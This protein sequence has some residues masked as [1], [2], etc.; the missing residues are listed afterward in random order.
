MKI[1][2]LCEN[3]SSGIGCLAE[4]GFSSFIQVHGKNLLFDTGYSDVY[5]HNAKGAGI[6]LESTDFILC[7]HFHSDH[8]GGLRYHTFRSKKKIIFH[9]EVLLKLPPE[10]ALKISHDFEVITTKDP[11]EFLPGL[12]F[13]G[14]IPRSNSFESGGFEGDAMRDDSAIAITTDKGTIIIS[15]CS[16][17]GICNICDYAKKVTGQSIYGVLGG[18][19]LFE[20]NN[21]AVEGTLSYFQKE[22]IP[23]LFPMHCVDF[24]TLAKF[25][26]LFKCK[27]WAAGDTVFFDS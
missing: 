26:M 24:P 27:K 17:S 23:H 13:L 22:Q 20:K 1:T 2:L 16:H 15:G 7:S 18:F 10:E 14:E 21:L 19:H 4:W 8:T 5:Q 9:P 3:A 6:D 25:Y 12:F 11:L